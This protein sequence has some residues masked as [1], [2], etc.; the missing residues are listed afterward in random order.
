MNTILNN[1]LTKMNYNAL[2]LLDKHHNQKK[3]YSSSVYNHNQL[4]SNKEKYNK[5][6]NIHTKTKEKFHLN[7]KCYSVKPISYTMPKDIILKDI[8]QQELKVYKTKEKY[9]LSNNNNE[10]NNRKQ[11]FDII[12]KIIADRKISYDIYIKTIY[13]FDLI[14]IKKENTEIKTQKKIKECSNILIALISFLLVLKFN[15]VENKIIRIKKIFSYFD[16]LNIDIKDLYEMEIIFL[17]LID[18]ELTF[19]TPFSFLDLFLINGIVFSEDYLESDTS[20]NIYDLTK[21]TLENIMETSNNYFKYNYL[22]LCCSII[23]FIRDKIKINKWPR[24]LEINFGIKFEEFNEVYKIFFHSNNDKKEVNR[25]SKNKLKHFYNS[26]IINIKNLKNINNIINVLKIMKSADK[27][28]RTKEKINKNDLI[29]DFSNEN[30]NE[31][32][33]QYI[34]SNITTNSSSLNKIKVGLKKNWCLVSYKSP[35]KTTITKSSIFSMISKLNEESISRISSLYNIK[36]SEK[37]LNDNKNI[38]DK[39]ND[40]EKREEK[41]DDNNKSNSSID[42]ISEKDEINELEPINKFSLAKSYNKY[43]QRININDRNKQINNKSYINSYKSYLDSSYNSTQ[44]HNY[45]NKINKSKEIKDNNL[46]KSNINTYNNSNKNINNLTKKGRRSEYFSKL[47]DKKINK[48]LLNS[49]LNKRQKHSSSNSNKLNQTSFQEFNFY[50]HK[51]NTKQEFPE[52]INISKIKEENSNIPT[53]ES[54]DP[55]LSFNEFN[56][57]KNFLSKKLIEKKANGD[58]IEE[59]KKN[60]YYNKIKNTKILPENNSYRRK[61]GVRKFYKQKNLIE[62]K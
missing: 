33:H 50:K 48:E 39:N 19:Q 55:K 20:F 11:I 42:N 15:H 43:K 60:K 62:K 37:K 3:D 9:D 7:E 59:N 12:K 51:P 10:N 14:N 27:P 8:F 45:F 57:R 17:K 26:D 2:L 22:H 5:Y 4:T 56:S 25:N 58:C 24:T 47:T 53:C 13:L 54:S 23:F 52:S 36:G 49:Y 46:S 18:Y 6:I 41:N 21:E 40:K 31:N 38:K 1:I 16:D 44:K 28:K 61:I 34:H 32:H 30:K 35:E 29:S